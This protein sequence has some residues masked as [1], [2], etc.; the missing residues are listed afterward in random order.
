MYYLTCKYIQ[1]TNKY[2]KK[3]NIKSLV[4]ITSKTVLGFDITLLISKSN[5]DGDEGGGEGV[6]REGY[7]YFY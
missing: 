1:N 4:R 6:Q 3:T 7:G 2:I 5:V